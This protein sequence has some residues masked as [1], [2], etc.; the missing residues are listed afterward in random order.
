MSP[1][2][3]GPE[4]LHEDAQGQEVHVAREKWTLS[5]AGTTIATRLQVGPAADLGCKQHEH[6]LIC[7]WSVYRP[8]Y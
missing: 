6:C 5:L 3:S 7:M 1:H 4:A 2:L 8:R